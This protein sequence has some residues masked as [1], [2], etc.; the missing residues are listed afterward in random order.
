MS[1]FQPRSLLMAALLLCTAPSFAGP[2]P[3][4]Y[5]EF[6]GDRIAAEP[7]NPELYL[8]RAMMH[9]D[10]QHH[11]L[12]FRDVAV[13]EK[14]A[15]VSLETQLTRGIL[16]YRAGKFGDSRRHFDQ[17]LAAQP[18]STLAL[19]YRA[20]LLRDMKLPNAALADYRRL[21]ALDPATDAGHYVTAATLMLEMPGEGPSAALQLLDQRIAQVGAIPQLQRLAIRME[22]GRGNQ[23]EVIR[24]LNTLDARTKASPAW[25]LEMGGHLLRH[26]QLQAAAEHFKIAK[27]GLKNRRPTVANELLRKKL[28]ELMDTPVNQD[29]AKAS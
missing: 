21:I 8:R 3:E 16:S 26:C 17:V 5:L 13:A 18:G 6:L 14:V 25:Q 22:A 1:A 20:R 27:T 23:A 12:A 11:A 24:R 10:S 29:C 15:G 4:E 2:S 19:S 28:A 7:K 9:S